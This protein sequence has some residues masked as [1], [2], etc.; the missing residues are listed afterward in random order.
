MYVL[1]MWLAAALGLCCEY[2]RGNMNDDD[3]D[4]QQPLLDGENISIYYDF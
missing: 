4:N 1:A 3:H 2:W